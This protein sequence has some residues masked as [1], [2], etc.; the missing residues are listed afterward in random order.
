MVVNERQKWVKWSIV[1]RPA[2]FRLNDKLLAGIVP[3]DHK[4]CLEKIL[5][6]WVEIQQTLLNAFGIL[7]RQ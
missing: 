7:E 2:G 1:T 3:K 4:G 6:F 5:A